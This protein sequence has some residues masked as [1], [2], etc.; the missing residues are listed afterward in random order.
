MSEELGASS[1]EAAANCTTVSEACDNTQVE[2]DIMR[3]A[4]NDLAEA[5]KFFK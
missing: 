1:E 3:S 5:I 2:A 4:N